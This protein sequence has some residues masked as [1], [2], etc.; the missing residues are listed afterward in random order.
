M[1]RK[2]YRSAYDIMYQFILC[3]KAKEGVI[4]PVKIAVFSDSHGDTANMYRA[5]EVY[6]PDHILHLGD[7]VRDATAVAACYPD[8]PLQNVAGNCDWMPAGVPDSLLIELGGVRIFAAHGHR[9]GVK[10]GLDSF[11][12]SVH[13]SGAKLGLFGHTHMAMRRDF[14]SIQLFNPGSCG[15]ASR[16]TYGQVVIE[17]GEVFCKIV[18]I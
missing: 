2:S 17:N 12:N 16:P 9:H 13:F 3:Q 10:M 5:I 7:G 14:G 4:T 1:I 18:Q 6:K 8:I 11:L 15:Y